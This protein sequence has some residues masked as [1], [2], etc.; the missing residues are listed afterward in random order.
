MKIPLMIR[1]LII[2]MYGNTIVEGED[3]FLI[4]EW[5]IFK[6]DTDDFGILRWT[7]QDPCLCVNFLDLTRIIKWSQCI[8]GV[9]ETN[10]YVLI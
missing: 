9:S 3:G 1:Y 2:L 5:N 6:R 7:L 8:Q 10:Q 4:N